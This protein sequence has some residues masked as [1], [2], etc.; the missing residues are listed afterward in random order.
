MPTPHPH[1]HT[2]I[3]R[4]AGELASRDLQ[5]NLVTFKRFNARRKLRAGIKAVV[6]AN[7]WKNIIGGFKS[8]RERQDMVRASEIELRPEEATA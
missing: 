3:T 2:Q 7:R 4:D 6:A 8:E 1:P 5:S